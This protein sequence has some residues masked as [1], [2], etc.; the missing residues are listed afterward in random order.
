MAGAGRTLGI[1]GRAVYTEESQSNRD[2]AD[3]T[4]YNRK[5][6]GI[7]VIPVIL[8]VVVADDV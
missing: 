8:S 4:D 3:S 1:V 6:C 5:I 7:G 2:Y